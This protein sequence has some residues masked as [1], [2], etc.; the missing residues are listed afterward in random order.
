MTAWIIAAAIVFLPL[1]FGIL[2]L[3]PQ[4]KIRVSHSNQDC[5]SQAM[6]AFP[7]HIIFSAF[8]CRCLEAKSL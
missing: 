4:T 5:P 2:L 1:V 6:L 3:G 8:L 7:G